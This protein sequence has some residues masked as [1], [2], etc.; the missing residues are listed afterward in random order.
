MS[1]DRTAR[2]AHKIGIFDLGLMASAY[3]LYAMVRQTAGDQAHEATAH[4]RSL[5]ALERSLGFFWEEQ[6]QSWVLG[7]EGLVKL[8]NAIYMYGHFPVIY[9]VGIWLFC[10]HRAQ[11]VVIRNAFLISGALSLAVFHV[12]P[13]TPPRLLPAHFGFVDTLSRYSQVNY[14]SAGDFVNNY[15]AMPSLH[16]GWNLLLV[17]GII[18]TVKNPAVRVIAGA[19]PVLMSITVVVTGNHYF[20]DIVGG[21]AVGMAGLLLAQQ[22]EC[23]GWKVKRLVLGS[24]E[25]ARPSLV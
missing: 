19:M 23:H 7:S 5:V 24:G 18:T 17:I 12:F 9:A 13:L 8:F 4:A 14:H 15:A 3:F 25:E 10:F 21:I 16:I 11:Y 22:L 1:I 6:V 20:L 2:I